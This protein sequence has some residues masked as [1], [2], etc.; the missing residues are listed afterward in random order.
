MFGL[1]KYSKAI[2]AAIGAAATVATAL[3]VNTSWIS[4]AI[5][6]ATALGVYVVPNKGAKPAK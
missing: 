6:V 2:T 3:N 5:A 4:V 1:A